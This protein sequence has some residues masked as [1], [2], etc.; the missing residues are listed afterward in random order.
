MAGKLC[1][2]GGSEG[3]REDPIEVLD[4]EDE[5]ESLYAKLMIMEESEEVPQVSGRLVVQ[6]TTHLTLS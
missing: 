5:G 6:T 2:C 4:S 1:H 3:S